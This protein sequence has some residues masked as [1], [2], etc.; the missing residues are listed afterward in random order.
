MPEEADRG[1]RFRR[2]YVLVLTFAISAIFIAMIWS[3]LEALLLA[4][5]GAGMLQPVYRYFRRLYHGR[6]ALASV[7][8][9]LVLLVII[10]GPLT[11]FLGIVVAQAI[12]VTETAIPWVREHL[13][14][15]ENMFS[16]EQWITDLVPALEGMMPTRSQ[17]LQGLGDVAQT[18][19]NFLVASAST[20]TSG[21]AAFLLNLFV[22]LYAMF[23]FLM[24]GRAILDRVLSYSPL[25]PEDDEKLVGRFLSVARATLKGS[26]IIGIVQG[27]L[28]GIGFAVA[29]I[30]GPA[31][32]G[33]V[34]AILSVIPGIGAAAV[35]IPA[36]VYLFIQGEAVVA[37]LLLA[38][39][40]GVVG[41]IDNVLRPR[42]VGQD[43]GMPDL[44]ILLSTLGGLFLFGGV[45]FIVGPIIG[46]LFIAVWEIYG[47][48]FKDHLAPLPSSGS[49]PRDE[50]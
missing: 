36:V 25:A 46:S 10:V 13:G 27:A 7:T 37:G 9:I 49:A 50:L 39:C 15:E 35:W 19:G 12:E 47:V 20:M 33:T 42:L 29:G 23:F 26:V 18:V 34:M 24:S 2:V 8:T 22:M 43:A 48:T 14:R 30:S 40:A 21:T 31:F 6:D 11:A 45:G 41:T 28:G 5:I 3:F 44:L 32:W 17:L 38:W 4:G 1:A 16:V